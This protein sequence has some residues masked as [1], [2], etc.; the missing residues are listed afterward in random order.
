MWLITEI[1]TETETETHTQPLTRTHLKFNLDLGHKSRWMREC[2]ARNQAPLI[3]HIHP[4]NTFTLPTHSPPPQIRPLH[5]KY[6]VSAYMYICIYVYA[7]IH[8]YSYTQVRKKILLDT[9]TPEI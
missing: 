8:I 2:E 4:L 6:Q 1:E 9:C 7:Y 3:D 5:R